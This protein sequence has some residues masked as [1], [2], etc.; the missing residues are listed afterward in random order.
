[1]KFVN[2]III[3]A[4]IAAVALSGTGCKKTALDTTSSTGQTIDEI[5]ENTRNAKKIIYGLHANMLSSTNESNFGH[6]SMMYVNDLMANDIRLFGSSANFLY[7]EYIWQDHRNPTSG[8]VLFAWSYYYSIIN[9]CNLIIERIDNVPYTIEGEREDIKGQALA[10]RAF[11]YMNLVQY[12]GNPATGEGVPIYTAGTTTESKPNARASIT[13]V[14][15]RIRED[16]RDAIALLRTPEVIAVADG[17]KSSINVNVAYGLMARFNLLERNWPDAEENADLATANYPLSNATDLM[18]GFNSNLNSEWI[19]ASTLTAEQY[20]ANG[21]GSLVGWMDENA[22]GYGRYFY[23]F[24]TKSM[25]NIIPDSDIR[26]GWWYL[27]TANHVQQTKF[28]AKIPNTVEADVPYMRSSEMYLI[29]AE[30]MAQQ[31]N[32][33][34]AKGILKQL[35]DIRNNTQVDTLTDNKD[36]VLNFIY[37]QRRVELWGEGHGFFDLK[38]TGRDLNRP[39][40]AGNHDLSASSPARTKPAGDKDWLF[41]IPQREF[42]TNPLMVQNPL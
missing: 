13:Q 26:K 42:E 40:G 11:A 2:K 10:Y 23:S 32:I 25:Y 16:L 36:I 5:F 1:M 15:D 6:V 31:D 38:R 29:M 22:S 4:G 24:T 35:L 28:R 34:G 21:Q 20:A 18:S 41:L 7:G 19:W 3:G 30:A 39:I 14:Y 12:F 37:D 27:L 9:N 17:E 8:R 33:P